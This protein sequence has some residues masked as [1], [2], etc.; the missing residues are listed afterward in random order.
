MLDCQRFDLVC[1]AF[2]IAN[3]FVREAVAFNK[4]AIIQLRP[5]AILINQRVLT[6]LKPTDYGT[7]W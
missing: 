6:L 1:V 4:S 2:V 3:A 5:V 7:I